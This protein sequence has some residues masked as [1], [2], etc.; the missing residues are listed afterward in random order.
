MGPETV[1]DRRA[2]VTTAYAAI[3]AVMRNGG[4]TFAPNAAVYVVAV[5]GHLQLPGANHSYKW[6]VLIVNQSTGAEMQA[7][8]ENNDGW[9][10]FFS[11]LSMG[12]VSGKV[13]SCGGFA[14]GPCVPLAVVVTLPGRD[15]TYTT[16]ASSKGRWSVSVPPGRYVVHAA[17]VGTTS[18]AVAPGA[19]VRGVDLA[20]QVP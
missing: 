10:S 13:E 15:S 16:R 11:R 4:E 5:A 17:G 8:C 3:S 18:V 1:I 12:T 20:E 2:V 7:L 19:L 14:P 9:P 6:C